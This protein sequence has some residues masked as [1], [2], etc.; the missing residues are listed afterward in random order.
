MKIDKIIFSVDDNPRYQG[1]WKINSEICKKVL[2]ITPILFHITDDQSEFYEDDFGIVKKIKKL[3]NQDTG[4]QS[5]IYRMYGTKY[6]PNEVCLISDIDMLITNKSY[7]TDQID[8]FSDDDMVVY[9]SDAYDNNRKECVGIY[10]EPRIPMCYNAAKGRT[11]DQ[12]I[13]TNRSFEDFTNEVCLVSEDVHDRDEIFFGLKL[14]K[15]KNQDKIKR[16]IRGYTSP[17]ICSKRNDRPTNENL[18]N[19]YDKKDIIN[20][21]IVDIHLS[22]PYTKHKKEI[23]ELR[24]IILGE[25]KEV[26]LI[27]CHIENDTQ[28]NMVKTLTNKLHDNNKDFIISTHTMVP[29]DVINKSK[30]FIYDSENPKYKIW[31][32]PNKTKYVID[33]GDF[34]IISPY[35]TY[36]R[37]DYYHVGPL[38]QIINGINLVKTM[39]YDVIHWMD[40]DAT[41]DFEE[42][43]KNLHRLKNY[44]MVFYG[45][46]P[47]FS[48]KVDKVRNELLNMKNENFLSLLSNYD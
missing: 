38:R 20:G 26:Y 39:D 33:V 24:K 40:Y 2:G 32:L 12:I 46:G 28:L 47:K 6:F 3:P 34:S 15:F 4:F 22:R 41:L 8:H 11:F 43:N 1:L 19:T 37:V 13:N 31:D 18:F 23:D 30:G 48:F 44:D 25:Y 21:N 29:Q 35:V 36:G 7:L 42:E 16:L 14:N 45:V 17:F 27:G 10:S 5:Q 9:I